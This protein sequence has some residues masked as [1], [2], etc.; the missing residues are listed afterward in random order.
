MP[1]SSRPTAY[2]LCG[3]PGSGKTTYA[4]KLAKETGATRLTLDEEVF[5]NFGRESD[6]EYK[7][8]ED[9]TKARLKDRARELLRHGESVVFDYGFW[10]KAARD[11]YRRFVEEL[12]ATCE[13]VYFATPHDALLQRIRERNSENPVENHIIDQSMLTSFMNEFEPPEDEG[14][15]V[16]GL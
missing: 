13:L 9:R 2:L 10:K 12:G 6:I 3:L 16:V 1:I 11:E 7:A 8:R 15:H 14:A 5:K 4:K